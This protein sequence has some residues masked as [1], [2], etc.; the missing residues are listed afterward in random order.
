VHQVGYL[1][2]IYSRC[3]ECVELYSLPL[4]RGAEAIKK[5]L[6]RSCDKEIRFHFSQNFHGLVGQGSYEA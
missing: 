2:G 4:W 5:G 3:Y 1:P 6:K